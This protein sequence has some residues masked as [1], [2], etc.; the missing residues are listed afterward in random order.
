MSDVNPGYLTFQWSPVLTNPRSS[1]IISSTEGSNCTNTS[2]FG[3]VIICSV[4]FILQPTFILNIQPAVCGHIFGEVSTLLVN[5]TKGICMILIIE[6]LCMSQIFILVP[7]TPTVKITRVFNTH[8]VMQ[9]T[10]HATV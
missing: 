2:T 4:P 9:T 3:N 1:Y 7:R 8:T 6:K 10:F 5:L